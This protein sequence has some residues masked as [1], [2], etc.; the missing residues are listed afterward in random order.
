ML[1]RSPSD[2]S[3]KVER[4]VVISSDVESAILGVAEAD[5]ADLIAIATRGRGGLKRATQ[6]SVSDGILR[7]SIVSTLVIHPALPRIERS[8][9][10]SVAG[11]MNMTMTV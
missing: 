7:Q 11:G 8:E 6:G 3:L 9:A 2:R 5:E 4:R 10:P 1:L